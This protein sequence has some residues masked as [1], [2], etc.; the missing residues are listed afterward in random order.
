ME[1]TSSSNTIDITGNI[2]SI[3]NFSEIKKVVDS[4]VTQ[5]KNIT[6]NIIDS[7]SITSS[8]IGYFNKLILKDNVNIEMRVGNDQLIH[9]LADLNLASTFKARKA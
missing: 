9:L 5:H 3:N 1:I 2:K 4:I 7:L 8:V 6:I